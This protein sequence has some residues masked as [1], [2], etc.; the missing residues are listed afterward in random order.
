MFSKRVK[1]RKKLQ[2]SKRD[3]EDTKLALKE[4][5]KPSNQPTKKPQSTQNQYQNK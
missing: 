3:D 5:P 1:A 2:P 4:K